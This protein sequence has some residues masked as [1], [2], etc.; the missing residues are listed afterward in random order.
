MA[1]RTITVLTDDLDGKEAE[2]IQTVAF[3]LAGT[4]YELD[5]GDKN[6]AKL[7]TALHP[8]VQAPRKVSDR[9][10]SRTR[11]GSAKTNNRDELQA[12]RDWARSNGHQ[13]SDRGRISSEVREAYDSAH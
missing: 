1:K 6:R 8:F 11:A 12:I 2:D 13:V 10:S 3:S 5:L 9:R 7:E 4:S